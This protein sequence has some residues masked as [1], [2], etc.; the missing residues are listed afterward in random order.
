M[1]KISLVILIMMCII[2]IVGC[3]TTASNIEQKHCVL[4]WQD[5]YNN[6][7]TITKFSVPEDNVTCYVMLGGGGYAA[8][9]SC[10]RD[11]VK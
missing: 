7:G 6:V 2:L 8:G 5:Y 1:K 11:E 9:I 4:Y 10:M 3:T